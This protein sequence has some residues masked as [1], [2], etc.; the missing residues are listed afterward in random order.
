MEE[1]QFIL[2]SIPLQQL[3]TMISVAVNEA[4]KI[5][6]SQKVDVSESSEQLLTVKEAA[7]FLNLSVPTVYSKVSK[8][9]LPVMKRSK[10]LYFSSQDLMN[11][12]KEGRKKTNAEIEAEADK[13]LTKNHKR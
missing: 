7:E 13:Y 2:T 4:L 12:I 11:Y 6:L 1:K 9:E 3:N 5:H 8:G 10:R